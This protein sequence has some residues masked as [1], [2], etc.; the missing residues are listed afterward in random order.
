M[1]FTGFTESASVR[2]ATASGHGSM[3]TDPPEIYFI[4]KAG[5]V[6]TALVGLLGNLLALVVWM[7]ETRYNA[8]TFLLKCLCV[9]DNV[10]LLTFVIAILSSNVAYPYAVIFVLGVS[11]MLSVHITLSATVTRL[12]A[13]TRPLHVRDILTP[14]RVYVIH[15]GVFV[16]CTAL[17]SIN[18]VALVKTQLPLRLR[19]KIFV[20]RQTLGFILP[21]VAL[22]IINV[23]L[24]IFLRKLRAV[25]R[26]S[27]QR[28]PSSAAVSADRR[29]NIAVFCISVCTFIAYPVGILFQ[30]LADGIYGGMIYFPLYCN[31]RCTLIVDSVFYLMQTLNSSVNIIFYLVFSTQFRNLLL[32]RV[33]R[34]RGLR[35]SLSTSSSFTSSKKTGVSSV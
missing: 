32:R 6:P 22:L 12:L 17:E 7:A 1:N 29:L 14:R 35:R 8:T 23:C 4:E 13:V 31:R 33:E 18:T 28:R 27:L 16:W 2:S 21:I 5:I 24:L 11:Q 3:K 26:A 25:S 15:A 34:V 19:W 9:W 30:V 10:F 20:S